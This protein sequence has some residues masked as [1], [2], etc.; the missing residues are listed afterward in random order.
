M[1]IVTGG[2]GFIGYNLIK[3]L[4]SL[5]IYKI[6]IVDYKKKNLN[7]LKDIKY[8][9]FVE[10]KSFYK[11]L[12][13]FVTKNTKCIFHQ[14]AN[15]STT[16]TNKEKIFQQNYF[17]SIKLIEFCQTKKIKLIYASSAATYGIKIKRFDEN[18][19]NL[20]P[21]N[22]YAKTKYLTDKYVKNIL[23]NKNHSQIVGLRY[24]NVYGPHEFHKKNMGSVMMNFNNQAITNKKI[25]LFKGN[26]G[27]GNGEQ[28]RDFIHINDCI[29]V[30]MFFFKKK[31]SGIFNVGTG[32]KNTFNNVANIILKY[33]KLSTK[34][35]CYI[36]FPKK[37]V[38]KYQSYTKANVNKLRKHGYNKKFIPLK[39]GTN[40]Y[41]RFLNSQL[42]K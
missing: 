17:S 14:G 29:D 23:K 25:R 35:L 24:F 13:K 40:N 34:D 21:G 12:E 41:L 39:D 6:I 5:K 31:I 2:L 26:N 4:N 19:W 37:L 1:I 38:G 42:K 22:L 8:S 28:I 10:V 16:E 9:K 7:Y 27:Y 30:N 3:K 36:N 20:K 11:N 18:N 32:K 15:S 33:H